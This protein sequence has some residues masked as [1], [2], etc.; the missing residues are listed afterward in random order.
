MAFRTRNHWGNFLWGVLHTLTI[1]DNPEPALQESDAKRMFRHIAAVAQ[2]I[3]CATCSAHYG[4]FIKSLEQEEK[5]YER[6]W[7]FERVVAFHNE[8]NAKLGK[9]IWTLEEAREH[10]TQTIPSILDLKCGY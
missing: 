3:P 8:V 4:E 7:L 6:M 5:R 10:W 9:R 2:V 1:L